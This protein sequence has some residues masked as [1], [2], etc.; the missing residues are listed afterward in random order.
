MKNW[1]PEDD[2]WEEHARW[3]GECAH[4]RLVKGQEFVEEVMKKAGAEE[5][6]Y[7]EEDLEDLDTQVDQQV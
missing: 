3:F 6:D 5:E 4:L 7:L 1:D 2:P